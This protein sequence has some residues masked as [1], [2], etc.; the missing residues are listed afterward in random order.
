MPSTRDDFIICLPL[1]P[2]TFLA[3]SPIVLQG[4]EY[5]RLDDAL[6]RWNPRGVSQPP[7]FASR[8]PGGSECVARMYPV[9]LIYI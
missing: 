4:T 5:G 6:K 9:N 8:V 7:E 1:D 3:A 2:H